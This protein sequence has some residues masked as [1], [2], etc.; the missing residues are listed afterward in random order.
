M[1]VQHTEN[2]LT[3]NAFNAN[4]AYGNK[5]LHSKYDKVLNWLMLLYDT[6]YVV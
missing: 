4:N 5:I 2:Q 1:V 6:Y 3:E